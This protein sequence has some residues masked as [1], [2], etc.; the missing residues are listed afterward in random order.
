MARLIP[1]R[2][3]PGT[4]SRGE[5][6]VFN[7]LREDPAADGWTVLH[8]LNLPERRNGRVH[9]REA[10]FVILIPG[11]GV[12]C[13]EVK[14][15]RVAREQGVWKSADRQGREH[16][17]RNPFQQARDCM[18]ALRRKVRRRFGE[19]T[20]EAS[21][22]FAWAVVLPDVPCP[23]PDPEF[24]RSQVVDTQNLRD[25]I[26]RSLMKLADTHLRKRQPRQ[27][28]RLPTPATVKKLLTF[29]RPDFDLVPA[30]SSTLQE[31]EKRLLAL[32]EEQYRHLDALEEN[33][34]CL[35]RGA[36]G[37]GKTML[38]V[39]A[40]RRA[41]QSGQ[42]VILTCYNR[43]LSRVLRAACAGTNILCG[44]WHHIAREIIVNSPQKEEFIREESELKAQGN[45]QK[46]FDEVFPFQLELALEAQGPRAD[47]LFLDE[48]QDLLPDCIGCFDLVLEGGL[49]QGRW[50][51]FGDFVRQAL[52]GDGASIDPIALLNPYCNGAF[53]RSRL[54]LNCRN[55]KA[56]SEQTAL[57]SGFAEPPCEPSKEVGL[58]VDKRYYRTTERMVQ[59]L[60]DIVRTLLK[61]GMTPADIILL[62]PRV[63]RNS[64]LAG[65]D[66]LAGLE[67][68]DFS[69]NGGAR[70]PDRLEYSTVHAFKGL[71]R[72]IVILIDVDSVEGDRY[73]SLLYVGMSRARGHLYLLM[74]DECRAVVHALEDAAGDGLP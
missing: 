41:A 21:T 53:T 73:Q 62:S 47:A 6:T 14:G 18:H 35:F 12:V 46:L 32:T 27:G 22:P 30:L 20:P 7:R 5:R 58:P 50:T 70:E 71:E 29:M 4:Q 13:L 69:L 1:A 38:A 44:S 65:I 25:S 43:N 8:S 63:R 36:A 11:E 40:A 66:R 37:T 57:L 10:D 68:Q 51:F 39:E 59:S 74:K 60:E 17:I 45:R 28:E 26:A 16:D 3:T 72:R 24:D 33:E 2:V 64:G 55:T 9:E 52:Y 23:P 34:R 31:S 15:G 54:T 67:I 56:I 61:R 42:R 48:A 49:A 19:N